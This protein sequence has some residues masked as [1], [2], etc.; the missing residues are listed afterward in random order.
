MHNHWG[1]KKHIMLLDW[2]IDFSSN[3]HRVYVEYFTRPH[4]AHPWH[5]FVNSIVKTVHHVFLLLLIQWHIHSAVFSNEPVNKR[6]ITYFLTDICENLFLPITLLCVPDDFSNLTPCHQVFI[7]ESRVPATFTEHIFIFS[8][9]EA[10][11]LRLFGFD[12]VEFFGKLRDLGP[13]LVD[14]LCKAWQF[15]LESY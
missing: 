6:L 4:Y 3:L 11:R 8:D 1:V 10:D 7:A 15:L 5:D 12:R 9:C 14:L 13:S 2:P